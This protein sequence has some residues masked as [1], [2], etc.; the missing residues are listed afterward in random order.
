[1]NNAPTLDVNEWRGLVNKT[2]PRTY[3][4]MG[5]QQ[6]DNLRIDR[7]GKLNTRQGLTERSSTAFRG[8]FS[9]AD[10]RRAYGVSAAGDL[11]RWPSESVLRSGFVGFPYWAEFTDHVLVGNASQVWRVYLDGNVVDNAMVRPEAPGLELRDGN[12][13]PGVYRFVAVDVGVEES[14]PSDQSAI[15]VDGTQN[16]YVNAPGM[17][18]YVCPAN[19]TSFFQWRGSGV[20]L[21]RPEQLGALLETRGLWPMPTGDCLAL[22]E[23][24]LY[25]ST[26]LPELDVSAVWRSKGLWHGLCDIR[27]EGPQLFAGQVRLLT[28]NAAG[29]LVGTDREIGAITD[30][31]YTKF[32]DFGVA[33]GLAGNV[34]DRGNVHLLTQRGFATAFPFRMVNDDFSPPACDLARTAVVREGGDERLIAMVSISGDPDNAA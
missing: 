2:E 9:T 23:E 26:Y 31:R 10:E 33:S 25:V 7:Q 19:S 3:G 27:G 14:A 28:G 17:R 1:M 30:E 13:P 5:M 18:I 22:Y 6:A 21:G 32:C 12:L 8:A 20:Y 34:D 15:E 4:L 29:L 16:I 11:V 24:A